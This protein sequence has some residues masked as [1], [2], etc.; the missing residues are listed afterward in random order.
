MLKYMPWLLALIA[1]WLI[2]APFLLGY[3]ETEFA[4]RN[5]VG[6]GT[7]ML[8]GALAWGVSEW[9]GHGLGTDMQT[10]HR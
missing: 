7:V 4:M 3:A 9:R 8:L 5:D 1:I 10:Q 6:V 2:A